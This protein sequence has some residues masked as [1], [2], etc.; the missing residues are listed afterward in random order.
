MQVF[1]YCK[2]TLHVSS[3]HH[4]HHQ[5]YIKLLL[6]PLVQVIVYEQQP[7]SNVAKGHVGGRLLLIL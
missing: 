3:V 4:T 5:E 2:I 6:Q 7:S 1:I